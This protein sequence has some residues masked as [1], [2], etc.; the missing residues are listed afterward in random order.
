MLSRWAPVTSGTLRLEWGQ[1]QVPSF[2]EPISFFLWAEGAYEPEVV[3]CIARELHSGGTFID[4]GAN[5][6]ALSLQV[7]RQTRDV[8]I[9]AIEPSQREY[10]CLEANLRSVPSSRAIR[11]LAAAQPGALS[12]AQQPARSFGSNYVAGD[13]QG[14]SIPAIT[15]DSLL[16]DLPGDDPLVIKMDIEGYEAMALQGASQLIRERRAAWVIEF[17]DWAEGRYTEPGTAQQ[18]LLDHGYELTVIGSGAPLTQPQRTGGA[19]ILAR[20]RP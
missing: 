12:L 9:L 15:L 5:V 14:T 13:G 2:G 17:M 8:E 10:R 3:R 18:I 20:P 7:A 4:V 19:M 16:D 11:A 6:G 1:L